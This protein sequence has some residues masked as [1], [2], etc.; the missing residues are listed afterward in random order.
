MQGNVG[1]AFGMVIAA[2]ACTCLGALLVCCTN[3]TNTKWLSGSLGASAG[4][5]M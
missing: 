5:M 4:V 1:L 2:G 3:L